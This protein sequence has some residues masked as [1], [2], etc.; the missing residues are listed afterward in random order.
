MLLD[1][2]LPSVN[3]IEILKIL[4][5]D[6]PACKVIIMTAYDVEYKREIDS[7]GYDGFF[8][9]PITF[10]NLKEKIEALLSGKTIKQPECK[11]PSQAPPGET[12]LPLKDQANFFPKARIAIIEIRENIAMLLKGYL[13]HGISDTCFNAVYFK[14]GT[15]F[16]NEISK[17]NPD[18]VL[19]DIV[20]IGS[21]S[22]FATRLMDL[23]SPPKEIILFGDPKFKWEEVDQLVKGGMNYIP[24]PLTSPDYMKVKDPEF[25]LPRKDTVERLIA[26]IKEVCFRYRLVAQKGA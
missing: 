13:E 7:I 19:Y 14:S 8:I 21:F 3:G 6:Y 17:F 25:E 22:E 20:E 12:A 24:T 23:P 16:L 15:F 10:E 2:K 26:V 5:K 11:V 1:I 18:I 4:R 9:K